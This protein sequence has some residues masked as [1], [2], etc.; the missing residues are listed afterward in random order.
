MAGIQGI[1][2]APEVANTRANQTRT[3]K[4]EE[5]RTQVKRD[6]V[7]LSSEAK[8]AASAGRVMQ[9]A[10]SDSGIRPDRVAAARENLEQGSYQQEH[11]LRTVARNLLKYMD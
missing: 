8:N 5:V 3:R 6:G 10:S 7:E 1:N 2:G 4:E 11:V 9:S